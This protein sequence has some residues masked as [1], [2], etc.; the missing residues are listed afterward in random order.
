MKNASFY[1]QIELQVDADVHRGPRG[2]GWRASSTGTTWSRMVA[3]VNTVP[4]ADTRRWTQSTRAE[5]L[6]WMPRSRQAEV[7]SPAYNR[8]RKAEGLA[9]PAL[10]RLHGRPDPAEAGSEHKQSSAGET[11]APTDSVFVYGFLTGGTAVPGLRRSFF[12]CARAV[13]GKVY[14]AGGHGE[15]TNTVRPELPDMASATSRAGSASAGSR[16]RRREGRFVGSAE[17]LDPATSTWS[18]VQEG[19][20]YDAACPRICSAG[21]GAGTACTLSAS[22]TSWRATVPP[23]PPSAAWRSVAAVPEDARTAA[24]VR[25]RFMNKV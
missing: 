15:E 11:W 21:P 12:A 4:V 9:P 16:R 22:G 25:T 8:L 10:A 3:P 2:L 24:S 5:A 6:A 19:L 13:G 20:V 7:E 1:V 17:S 14:V 23:P 18:P